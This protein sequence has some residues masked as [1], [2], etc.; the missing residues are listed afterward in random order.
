[1]QGRLLQAYSRLLANARKAGTT[2]TDPWF[3]Q[4][5]KQVEEK[6]LANMAERGILK[7]SQFVN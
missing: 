6:L 3:Q 7:G 4:Y 5:W 1:M 2:A